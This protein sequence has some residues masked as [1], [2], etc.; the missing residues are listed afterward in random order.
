MSEPITLTKVDISCV[1]R[2]EIL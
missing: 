1:C 2:L